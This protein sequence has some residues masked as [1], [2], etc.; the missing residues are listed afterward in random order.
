MNKSLQLMIYL[1]KSDCG[2][3]VFKSE[4]RHYRITNLKGIL[5]FAGDVA[6][7]CRALHCGA[8]PQFLSALYDLKGN[9]HLLKCRFV[10]QLV[11]LKL[12]L[13]IAPDAKKLVFSWEGNSRDFRE[14]IQ[15]I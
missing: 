15:I 4:G 3:V 5:S 2:N 14:G 10:E 12:W 8:A 7:L 1:N 9:T 13:A 11:F 6:Q